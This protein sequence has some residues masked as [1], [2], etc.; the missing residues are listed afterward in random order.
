VS[1]DAAI[2]RGV[3]YG[4]LTASSGERREFHG[5]LDLSIGLRAMLAPSLDRGSFEFC[6]NRSGSSAVTQNINE[7]LGRTGS[8]RQ[9]GR[10]PGI[11]G[12]I[13]PRSRAMRLIKKSSVAVALSSFAPFS[14]AGETSPPAGV[15]AVVPT[16]GLAGGRARRMLTAVALVAGL[17]A[18]AI[19]IDTPVASAAPSAGPLCEGFSACSSAPYSTH[20]YKSEMSTLWWPG[21]G[22]SGTECTNYAAWVESS[23]YGVSTPNYVLGDA[24]NWA[25]A[26]KQHGVTVNDTPTVGSVAQWYANDPDIGSDGHVA[27]V[28]EVGPN[29]SYIVISQDNWSSDGPDKYGW[30]LISADAPNQGEPWPDNFIHFHTTKAPPTLSDTQPAR[31]IQS[32]G[33]LYWTANQTLDGSSQADVFRASKDNEPGQEQLLYQ[34]SAPATSGSV[35]FDAITYANVGGTWYGYFVANYRVSAGPGE[36]VQ[37]ES[38]IKRVPLTGGSAIVLATSPAIIGNRD[39]VTD[40]SFLYWADADG[41]RRMTIA[42][43]PVQTLVSGTT[44]AHL[45]LDGPLLYYSSANSILHVPTSGG[46]STTV[47]S[48]ASTITAIYPPSATNT[49]VYWGEANGSVSLFPGPYDSAYQLQAPSAGVSVTSVSLADNYILWGQCLAAACKVEGYDNGNIVSAPT[50]RPPV[51]LQGDASAW[52]WGDSDLEKYTL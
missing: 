9:R 32:T 48:G 27:I 25:T 24:N 44:F 13:N 20:N 29:D 21:T 31:L 23:V 2:D 14:A 35:A 22:S 49:N 43:G 41:I 37:N 10:T 19:A 50:T 42:G 17:C 5:W 26:A 36:P 40:G 6:A 30:A 8:R 11:P 51:D 7:S 46:A 38:Q 18:G 12:G 4:T 3:I 33:N 52:Y 39:L 28:E 45:G 1:L 47:V 15:S 34:E 16:R